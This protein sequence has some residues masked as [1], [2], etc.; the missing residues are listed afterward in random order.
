MNTTLPKVQISTVTDAFQ[1]VLGRTALILQKHSPQILLGAGIIGVTAGTVLACKAT[2]KAQSILDEKDAMLDLV[3]ET[4]EIATPEDY[5]PEDYQKD[6]A[7][8]YVKTGVNFVKL[9]APSALLIAGGIGA[10]V[11]SHNIQ[12]GRASCRERV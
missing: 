3:R 4:K 9:Y 6:V 8:T 2:L 7:I 5:S 12:I 10:L 1:K 11:A